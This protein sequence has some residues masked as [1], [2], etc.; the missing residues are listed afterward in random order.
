MRWTEQQLRDYEARQGC[1]PTPPLTLPFQS[2]SSAASAA[3]EVDLHNS[4][5]SY[6][7]SHGYVYFHGSMAHKAMRVPGEPDF[8]LLLPAGRVLLVEAK[9]RTGKLSPRQLGLKLWAEKLGHTIH[10]VRSMDEFMILVTSQK[11]LLIKKP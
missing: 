5:I 4:I 7:K 6:C 8:I 3:K 11:P 2:E 10:V 1:K 9:T